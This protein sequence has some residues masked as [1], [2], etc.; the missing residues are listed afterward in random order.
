[1]T[2]VPGYIKLNKSGILSERVKEAE[3]HLTECRLCP[4][5]CGV[6]RSIGLGVCRAGDK[7][8]VSS[9]GPHFG[10][11]SVLVGRNGSGT[12]FFSHCN[13]RCVFCQNHNI[14]Q[15]GIG[16]EISN[17]KLADIMLSLQNYYHCHNINLVT[18]THYTVQILAALEIAVDKGLKLP[19]VYNCGGYEKVETLQA[20]DGIV[21]I[22][23][24]DFKY[25]SRETS[26]R[27]SDAE[28]YPLKAM[29][30]LREMDRQEGTLELDEAGLAR[31]GLLIRHLMLP[32]GLRDT[33]KILQFIKDELS[34]GVLVNLMNQYYPAHKAY[35]YSELR[36]TLSLKE[37]RQ[38]YTFA[39][40]LDLWLD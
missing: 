21:D 19:L 37:Y 14:S 30:A 1:M 26:K 13:L 12:I 10:E 27:Y 7:A 36:T 40:K 16:T 11:E 32:G 28:D 9:Y 20:L 29:E 8:K 31:R 15:S 24:P 17:E 34:D 33:K 39:Q 35:A 2:F 23:M 4:H 18:P 5:E 38:A 3:E 25:F 6:N 22:Y